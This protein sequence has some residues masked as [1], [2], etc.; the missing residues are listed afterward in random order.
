MAWQSNNRGARR[1]WR[2]DSWLAA[3]QCTYTDT[4]TLGSFHRPVVGRFLSSKA[5]VRRTFCCRRRLS[6]PIVSDCVCG[7]S[8]ICWRAAV[9]PAGSNRAAAPKW[10]PV[11][12]QSATIDLQMGGRLSG[13]KLKPK[14]LL[15]LS[16]LN[17]LCG[18][19]SA[20]GCVN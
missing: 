1:A 3:A 9:W 2:P 8:C 6:R 5:P 17:I 7:M 12:P 4:K 18:S 13:S 14:L 19:A 11:S 15:C 20:C 16:R 10:L